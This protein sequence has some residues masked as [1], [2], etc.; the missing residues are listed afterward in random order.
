MAGTTVLP[1]TYLPAVNDVT[2]HED[3]PSSPFPFSSFLSDSLFALDPAVPTPP[4]PA[5]PAA[6]HQ[7]GM[8]VH[9]KE[10]NPFERSFAVLDSTSIHTSKSAL[11]ATD[12][13]GQG[14]QAADLR[15]PPP[16]NTR[17]RALSSP[18]L[19]TPGETS[20]VPD[21][22]SV[23]AFK[24]A[25]RPMLQLA[26][27]ERDLPAIPGLA[28]RMIDSSSSLALSDSTGSTRSLRSNTFDNDPNFL[29]K[30][31]QGGVSSVSP[32][33]SVGLSPPDSSKSLDPAR[34]HSIDSLPGPTGGRVAAPNFAH[35]QPQPIPFSMP[36]IAPSAPAF[37]ANARP[38]SSSTFATTTLATA[39]L[40]LTIASSITDSYSHDPTM[41]YLA[42]DANSSFDYTDPFALVPATIESSAFHSLSRTVSPPP[43][44]PPHIS[45]QPLERALSPAI[46]HSSLDIQPASTAQ[47]TLR[48]GVQ[49]FQQ[50]SSSGSRVP[51]AHAT[52]PAEPP[53]PPRPTGKK[54][55]RKPKNWDP[56]LEVEIELE[57]EEQERQRKLAL[58]R[59]RVAASKSRR[60]KKEKVEALEGAA[61]DYCEGNQV[62]Q[63]QCQALLDEVHQLRAFLIQAHPQPGCQCHHV[64]GYFNRERDGG[65]IHA[66]MYEARGTLERDFSQVPTWGAN[67]DAYGAVENRQPT[68]STKSGIVSSGIG[69]PPVSLRSASPVPTKTGQEKNS[70]LST[71]SKVDFDE[72][73]RDDLEVLSAYDSEAEERVALK[74]RRARAIPV[75]KT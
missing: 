41:S 37:S 57:P 47:P 33:S 69:L 1:Q 39:S 38:F 74:S 29:F 16:R 54:R 59:N 20:G 5:A 15:L 53:V 62:L 28:R 60:R 31:S 40:P 19:F 18:A 55:G 17:K 3:V 49:P 9:S 14:V 46:Q 32:D 50:P 2:L 23:Q 75:R 12:R 66:I 65:G 52:R 26:P 71:K 8:F 7:A 58:E 44:P 13:P 27:A 72:A 21:A 42:M 24:Q 68:S 64:H 34:A 56:S 61:R 4:P 30:A 6:Q 10:I 51:P 45:R 11:R 43:P 63:S 35:F 25:K 67:D 73:D 36:S 48:L 70:K 22:G